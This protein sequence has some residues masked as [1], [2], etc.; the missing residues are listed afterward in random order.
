MYRIAIVDDNDTWCFALTHL[1]Y[2]HGYEAVAFTNAYEF[3]R[4]AGQY[5]LA[6][7]DFSIPPR[8]YQKAM[9]G[10]ELIRKIKQ[11]FAVPPVMV[12]IS[13]FFVDEV[14]AQAPELFPCADA[15]LSKGLEASELMAKIDRL[16]SQRRPSKVGGAVSP[17]QFETSQASR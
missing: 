16:L 4:E 6:L 14:L 17:S 8:R 11:Q 2:Q 9:D 12:L 15:Y 7:I 13:S 1:F 3:L 5:D 10:P